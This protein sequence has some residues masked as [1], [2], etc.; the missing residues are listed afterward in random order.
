M[1]TVVRARTLASLLVVAASCTP[2]ATPPLEPLGPVVTEGVVDSKT[3]PRPTFGTLTVRIVG[4]RLHRL[5]TSRSADGG[6]DR[7]FVVETLADAQCT[8][9]Y[10]P[11][12]VPSGDE[13]LNDFT[14]HPSGEVSL[15]LQHLTSTRDAF[16]VLRFSAQG[17]L[18]ERHTLSPGTLLPQS[19]RG[20]LP[21]PP[22]RMDSD[23][24][25][26]ALS[27]GWIRVVANGEDAVVAF[28]SHVDRSDGQF[29]LEVASAVVWLVWA[30]GG[31]V[32]TRAR[33][34]DGRHGVG[35]A[36]WTYDEFRWRQAAV[37]PYLALDPITGHVVVGRA[38]N[39][40]R[41]D[42]A[43]EIFQEGTAF[44]CVFDSVSPIDNE[45]LPFAWTSF[46]PDG[47]REGTRVW[48]PALTSEFVVF[49]MAVRDGLVAVVG[50]HVREDTEG[51]VVYYDGNLV[52]YDGYVALLDRA[53]GELRWERDVDGTGR[54]DVL[55]TLR[56]VEDGVLAGGATDWDRWNGGMSISRGAD[57]WLVFVSLDGDAVQR[58]IPVDAPARHTHLLGVDVT[59]GPQR[60]IVG[61]G[62]GD[63]PM[64]HSGDGGQTAEMVFGDVLVTVAGP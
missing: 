21:E 10:P 5:Q 9:T 29:S 17:E 62:L 8:W 13:F 64:T 27:E 19:D 7:R 11:E 31:Y 47:T 14:V 32:E 44:D 1:S 6:M 56:F 34:V 41:C 51:T 36:A 48:M 43:V 61:A 46:A 42:A 57:P 50:A 4:E 35:P 22:F 12:G 24:A 15:T 54:G 38:W 18:V 26:D 23:W 2:E 49:D 20:D 59:E 3:E 39:K 33:T 25:D 37:R 30:G 40:L 28:Q 52:P 53:T 55:S 45:R 16:E 63:A 60:R 58:S